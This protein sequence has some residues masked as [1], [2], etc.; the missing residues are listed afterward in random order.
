MQLRDLLK[1]VSTFPWR[2]S[3]YSDCVLIKSNNGTVAAVENC[4][5]GFG[6]G[7]REANAVYVNHVCNEVPHVLELLHLALTSNVD[8]AQIIQD[9][10][11]RLNEVKS[12]HAKPNVKADRPHNASDSKAG[13]LAES[14]R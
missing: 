3:R 10:Y 11:T 1:R 4:R 12:P 13:A 14:S 2:L 5:D 7:T 8:N 6:Q 9:A